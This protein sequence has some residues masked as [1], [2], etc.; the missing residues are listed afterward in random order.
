V[1]RIGGLFV[2]YFY[3]GFCKRGEKRS[4]VGAPAIGPSFIRFQLEVILF[5]K[6]GDRLNLSGSKFSTPGVQKVERF[7]AT[8]NN[9]DNRGEIRSINYNRVVRLKHSINL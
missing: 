8:L 5:G 3:C 9:D 2:R 6:Q 4:S 7:R 1:T